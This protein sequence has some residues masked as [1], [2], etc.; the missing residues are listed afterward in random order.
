MSNSLSLITIQEVW[1]IEWLQLQDAKERRERI[2]DSVC[3]LRSTVVNG[4]VAAAFSKNGNI[5]ARMWQVNVIITVNVCHVNLSSSVCVRA[6]VCVKKK[7]KQKPK[8]NHHQMKSFHTFAVYLSVRQLYECFTLPAAKAL[9]QTQTV[10]T[11]THTHKHRKSIYV[12]A[13][14]I[15]YIYIV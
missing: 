5:T 9:R 8:P 3:A 14:H 4:A 15:S 12:L 2:E 13:I 10:L 7:T 11:H 1:A 6:C